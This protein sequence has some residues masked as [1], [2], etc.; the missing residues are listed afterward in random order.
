MI[1][2]CSF[3]RYHLVPSADVF[4]YDEDDMVDDPKLAAHLA[5]F[6]INMMI[7]EK[8]SL[9]ESTSFVLVQ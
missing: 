2:F 3:L 7:M 8:V 1:L 4:S 9:V 6:G 5:H